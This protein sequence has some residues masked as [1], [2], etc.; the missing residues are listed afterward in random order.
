MKKALVVLLILAVAG[1][2]FAQ[3]FSLSGK[4]DAWLIPFQYINRDGDSLI[5]AGLG[6]DNNGGNGLRGRL[7]GEAKT[8]TLGLRIQLQFYPA[9]ASGTSVLSSVEYDNTLLPDP[10]T[11]ESTTIENF[12]QF[13]DFVGVWW[14]PIDWFQLDVGKFVSDPLRGK[15]G[16]GSWMDGV[17][18][19]SYDGDEIFSRFKSNGL[20]N[21]ASGNAGVLASF[22]L[23]DL[24]IGALVPNLKA[25][26]PG[27]Y[28]GFAGGKGNVYET[29]N[30]A[31]GLSEAGRVYER[32]QV[33]VG[34]TIP[35]IGLVRAQY[36]GANSSVTQAAA[37]G[38]YTIAA[39]RIE[40][41]FAFTAVEGLTLDIGGKVP[42]PIKASS[43][44]S[45]NTTDLEWKKVPGDWEAQA[46][47]QVSVGVSYVLDALTIN[48]RVDTKF[49]GSYDTGAPNS[50]PVKF[51]PEV[52]FHLFPTYDLGIMVVGL[53]FGLAWYG[54]TT[55]DGDAI[56]L[57][58]RAGGVARE[59]DGG[60]RVGGGL[61]AQKSWGDCTIRGGLAVKAGTEVN[62]VKEDAIFTIPIVFEY[63][64]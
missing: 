51:G 31:D 30:Y 33:A 38:A 18:V 17:T 54:E 53:D 57:P 60:V 26:G 23:G 62:G 28:E 50:D 14:K 29:V 32:I 34:Y 11:T 47:Y 43:Q 48:G 25:F 22:T 13:D 20:N 8:D 39:P 16:D 1:G 63:S 9:G 19:M 44:K 64:F 2:L 27:D 35:D 7:F 4:V 12:V 52:N 6:R 58:A 56:F 15:I 42:L 24:F 36:V 41:A 37:T 49:A 40:A 5:G 46:P 21:G 45:W 61:Y 55:E 10:L 59:A 3:E